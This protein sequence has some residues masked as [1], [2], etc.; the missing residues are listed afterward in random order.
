[1][2]FISSPEGGHKKF[3]ESRG[4][5]HTSLNIYIRVDGETAWAECYSVVFI[6]TS[7]DSFGIHTGAYNH[8]DFRLQDGRWRIVKRRRTPIG[9]SVH[10]PGGVSGREVMTQFRTA[11]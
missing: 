2:E 6:R 10:E 5:Q 7:A 3:V 9:D 4:S 8:W 1:M 11:V